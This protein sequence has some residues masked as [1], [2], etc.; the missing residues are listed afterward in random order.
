MAGGTW[1]EGSPGHWTRKV[2]SSA[3]HAFDPAT[4]RWRPLPDEPVPLAYSAYATVGN[5]L[6]VIGGYTGRTMNRNIYRLAKNSKQ[7]TW[8]VAPSLTAERVFARAVNVGTRIYLVGGSTQ[9]EP[10]D[11]MG[12]CCTTNTATNSLTTMDTAD[13]QSGWQ[14]LGSFPGS[15]RRLMSVE[16]DGKFIWMFDGVS[17][18]SASEPA[19]HYQ[20]VLRY[21]LARGIWSRMAALPSLLV[22][23]TPLSSSYTQGLVLL[24][25]QNRQTWQFDLRTLAYSKVTPLPVPAIVDR[26]FWLRGMIVGAGG[27]SSIDLPRRRSEWTLVGTLRNR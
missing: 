5:R 24:V 7:Y 27:E 4:R 26:F 6:Y 20:D 10:Y 1:W 11:S 15:A 3:T 13:M 21:D 22:S 17:Q 8:S 19:V 2:Y 25:G 23:S 9:F 12:T 18:A 16:T 14:Q